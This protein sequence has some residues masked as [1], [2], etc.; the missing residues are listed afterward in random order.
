MIEGQ[1]RASITVERVAVPGRVAAQRPN[2]VQRR[3]RRETTSASASPNPVNVRPFGAPAG[4][5]AQWQP[6]ELFPAEVV[7]ASVP[8]CPAAPASWPAT[9]DPPSAPPSTGSGIAAAAHMSDDH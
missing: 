5:V 9:I 3:R 8:P 2:V 6:L 7:P 1:H 4:A